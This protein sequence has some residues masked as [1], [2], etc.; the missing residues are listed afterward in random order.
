MLCF[1][2]PLT[3]SEIESKKART[4][5]SKKKSKKERRKERNRERLERK[6]KKEMKERNKGIGKLERNTT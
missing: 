4:Q 6:M 3:P 5:D 1:K 2:K